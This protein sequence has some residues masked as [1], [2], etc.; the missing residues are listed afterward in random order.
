MPKDA[1]LGARGYEMVLGQSRALPAGAGYRPWRWLSLVLRG[2]SDA[3]PQ[4][5]P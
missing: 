4:L 3:F 1:L 5:K 2:P